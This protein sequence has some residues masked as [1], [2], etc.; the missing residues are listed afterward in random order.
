VLCE[1]PCHLATT[2]GEVEF[3]QPT[4]QDACGIVDL[5]MA[6]QMDGCLG[7]VYQFLKDGGLSE[8]FYRG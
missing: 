7:H 5:A 8:I 2:F 3:G 6:E 1:H 4:I